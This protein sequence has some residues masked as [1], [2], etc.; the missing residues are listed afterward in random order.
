MK[1]RK[2]S[3]PATLILT[4]VVFLATI[5]YTTALG[6]PPLSPAVGDRVGSPA[7]QSSPSQTSAHPV[8]AGTPEAPAAERKSA[9]QTPAETKPTPANPL[10]DIAW[11]KGGVWVA[12]VKDATGAVA[13]RIETR[14]RGS[15]NGHLIKFTTTFVEHNRPHLQYEGVYLHDPQSKQIEFY[16]TDSE[17]NFTRGHAAFSGSTLTQDFDIVHMNG[18]ADTLRSLV[19]RD[20]EN[21]YN[22]SVMSNK[23]GERKELIHLRYVREKSA[24]E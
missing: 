15:E 12:E 5:A 7:A 6:A 2:I 1:L 20:G 8:V 4:I 14:I 17:G 22:W 18:Q 3:G 23:S 19:V 10:N 9:N 21:A 16:Y 13:T 24:A 11:M